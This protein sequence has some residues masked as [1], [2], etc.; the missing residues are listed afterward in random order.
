MQGVDDDDCFFFSFICFVSVSRRPPIR[1]I[2]PSTS[3]DTPSDP[4]NGDRLRPRARAGTA[5]FAALSID[6]VLLFTPVVQHLEDIKSHQV[7][8]KYRD[9]VKL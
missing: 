5:L 1:P 7:R 2:C 8:L 4:R 9:Y 3:V 6:A